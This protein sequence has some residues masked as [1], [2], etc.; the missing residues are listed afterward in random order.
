MI[1]AQLPGG[2]DGVFIGDLNNLVHERHV[3]DRRDES[4]ADTLNLVQAGLVSQKSRYILGFDGDDLDVRLVF[5]QETPD[6]LE[7]AAAA[8]P[9][10]ETGH[11]ARHLPPEF[12]SGFFV[13]NPGVIR[14]LELLRHEDTGVLRLEL[15]HPFHR[16]V[17]AFL[18]RGE[19]EL[20]PQRLDELLPFFAH[21]FGHDD[22]DLVPLEAPHKGDPDARVA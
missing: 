16:A 22:M 9:G 15:P 17:E 2:F 8:Y 5:L 12:V 19:N 3:Q 14:V 1:A 20:C 21:V 10:H 6:A 7:C 18:G 11:V 13:M 4:V